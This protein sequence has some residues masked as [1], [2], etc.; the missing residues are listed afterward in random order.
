VEWLAKQRK[1]ASKRELAASEVNI[2]MRDKG[3][4]NIVDNMEEEQSRKSWANPLMC[5]VALEI[6][7]K[8]KQCNKMNVQRE[9]EK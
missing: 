8:R 9:R 1:A 7:V 3:K 2:P 6:E 5:K 4:R